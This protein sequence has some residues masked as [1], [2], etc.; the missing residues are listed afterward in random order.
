MILKG[1]RIERERGER[2]GGTCERERER[3]ARQEAERRIE[4][5]YENKAKPEGGV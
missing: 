5:S 2:R 4:R 1:R 3:E